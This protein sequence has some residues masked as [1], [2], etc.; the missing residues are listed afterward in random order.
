MPAELIVA[1]KVAKY[2]VVAIYGR[3]VLTPAEIMGMDIADTLARV[4]QDRASS[5][6]A[7]WTKAHPKEHEF[8]EAAREI[9]KASQR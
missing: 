6:V 5:D 4:F 8:L 7:E 9:W 3:D 1:R 2:G